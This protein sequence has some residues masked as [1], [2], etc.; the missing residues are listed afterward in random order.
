[1]IGHQK[2]HQC[3]SGGG[4]CIPAMPLDGENLSAGLRLRTVSD[5]RD[6]ERFI[7]FNAAVN[8]ESEGVI[9]RRLL[10]GHPTVRR[11]DFVLI[12]DEKS[13]EVVSS[14][15][16]IPWRFR[17]EGITLDVAMLEMVLT[18]PDYRKRGLVRTQVQHFHETVRARGFDLC[19]I[20]GIAYYYRQFGYAYALDLDAA[21]SLPAWR[22]PERL[23]PLAQAYHLRPAASADA[24]L[25]AALYEQG[26]QGLGFCTLR[27]AEYWRYLLERAQAPMWLLEERESGR[28][29]GYLS[30]ALL[31]GNRGIRV[32]ESVVPGYEAGLAVFGALKG[33]TNGE[34]QLGWPQT[35]ALVQLARSL[36]S[37]PLPGYQW[38]VRIPDTAAWLRKIGPALEERLAASPAAGLT[39]ELII[40]L[41]REGFRL[42]FAAG[43]LSSVD[44]L[45]FVDA[46]MGADGGDLCIPPEAFVRLTLGYRNLD[47]LRD[48]W[49]DITIRPERRLLVDVLFPRLDSY[50]CAIY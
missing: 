10:Y 48:A 7:A 43:R 29:V 34:I 44:A 16:L 42:R 20:T 36:G 37:T 30:T 27:T 15:C 17:L 28:A 40:N 45:G 9:C 24:P 4:N 23:A 11:E 32:S 50:L 41:Y 39:G 13:G 31:P 26:M 19:V 14:T 33:E 38:L 3:N 22:I 2:S 49:P 1:M 25:L 47:E 46:S 6:V 18:H 21:D 12:E 35:G 5:E 8:G